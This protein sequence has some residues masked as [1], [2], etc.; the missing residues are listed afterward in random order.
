[1]EFLVDPSNPMG[2]RSIT[3]DKWKILL[4]E[5]GCSILSELR[6]EYCD[7]F[8]LSESSLF[9]YPNR[10][11]IK[12]CGQITLLKCVPMLLE[13]GKSVGA[14]DSKLTFARR[15][16]FFPEEQ[17]FPHNS[18]DNE[19]AYLKQH[20][21]SGEAHVFG[22]GDCD[23]HFL[24]IYNNPNTPAVQAHFVEILMTGLDENVMKRFYKS[25][26][27]VTS[28][29]FVKSSGISEFFGASTLIDAHLFEPCGFSSNA[30]DGEVYYTIHITPQKECS[31][32]SFEANIKL[33][34]HSLVDKVVKYFNPR[35]FT[36]LNL[37]V[38]APFDKEAF[39]AYY[40]RGASHHDFGNG[41]LLT[42]YSLKKSTTPFSPVVVAPPLCDPFTIAEK[43]VLDISL[44]SVVECGSS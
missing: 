3:V 35:T 20:F 21:P 25:D 30:L 19:V 27:T 39:P 36:V 37:G 42:W 22:P 11:M 6:N 23:Q 17:K 15:N 7:A 31:Y 4:Q 26:S 13:F 12:T 10:V 16:F 44:N 34:D 38:S 41:N 33:D 8:I 9:V 1:M 5:I 14:V 32:V 40:R 2:L 28:A 24:F 18:F 43:D 29:Q